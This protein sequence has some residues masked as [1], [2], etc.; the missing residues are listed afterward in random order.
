M[1]IVIIGSGKIGTALT[2]K[3]SQ[4]GH[5]ITVIDSNAKV[6]EQN[7]LKYDVMT[8]CGN[9]AV[10]ATL[11][12]ADAPNSDLIIAATSTDEVNILVC[13]LAKRMGAKRTIVRVRN[14]EYFDQLYIMRRDLGFSMTLNPDMDASRELF[15]LLQ[16]PSFLKRETFAKGR[17]EIVELNI[18]KDSLLCG[19]PVM[20]LYD[21]A[22][23]HV[24]VCA[25]RRGDQT[26]IPNGGYVFEEGDRISVTANSSDLTTMIRNLHL[27]EQKIRNVMIIGGSRTSFYLAKKL[28]RNK[29]R[30]K[31]IENNHARCM[32]LAASLPGATI[33]EG[34]GTMPSL[35]QEEDIQ[36]A[37]AVLAM[38]SIDEENMI[39]SLYAKSQGVQTVIPKIN[40][41]ELL[42]ISK[43]IGLETIINPKVLC[44]N[45]IVRYVR[46]L[47]NTEGGSM[48]TL[49]RIADN[50]VEA[51][52][53]MANET[54][55]YLNQPLMNIPIKK[56]II[57]A[58]INRCGN[59]FSPS[60]SDHIASGDL[61]IV[62]ATSQQTLYDLNDIFEE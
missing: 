15:R 28:L 4:E 21:F 62:A 16:F 29:L 22:K 12:E 32:A 48:I 53:F 42:G 41:D 51:L 45:N 50:S 7:M 27:G 49:H 33:I 30:V 14:P 25:V 47:E 9:G 23:V 13:T 55:H 61:V 43:T 17:V 10:A 1:K 37:D 44:C 2:D 40:R 5:D 54:T 39:L 8:V 26:F 46:A 3:L 34:D 52:E 24:L 59:S 58:R 35:L 56:N 11:R 31:I 18:K 57:I 36:S 20:K 60:G 38:T 19:V 6:L